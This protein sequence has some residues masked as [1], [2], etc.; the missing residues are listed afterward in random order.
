MGCVCKLSGNPTSDL[1][2]DAS[3]SQLLAL[4]QVP[5]TV[6]DPTS[7]PAALAMLATVSG[8]VTNAGARNAL[9]VQ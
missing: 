1:S 4:P 9:P 2:A 7:D 3:W 8:F 5:V 6:A